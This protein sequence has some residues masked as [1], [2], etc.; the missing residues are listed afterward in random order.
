VS[1]QAI[2]RR[3]AAGLVRVSMNALV[4]VYRLGAGRLLG[5]R[6]LLLSFAD[7][8][9]GQRHRV[10]EVVSWDGAGREAV[11]ISLFGRQ[12]EWYRAASDGGA[13]EVVI[14]GEHLRPRVRRIEGEEAFQM[15]SAFEGRNRLLMPVARPFISR[16]AGFRYDGSATARRRLL[17]KMPLLAFGADEDEER[18]A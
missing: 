6:F 9:G 18:T 7:G 11:A 2:T 14:A 10:L 3:A 4:A 1:S 15:F 5:H 17:E 8:S 13:A 16:L 12:A